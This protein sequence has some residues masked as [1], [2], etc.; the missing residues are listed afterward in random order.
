VTLTPAFPLGTA[1]LPG[2][3]VVLRVFESRY[4]D[5]VRQVLETDRTFVSALISAGSEVGGGDKRFDV[6]VLVEV[7]HVEQADIGLMLYGHAT[8]AVNITQWND[9]LSYPCAETSQQRSDWPE[10]ADSLTRSL[11]AFASDMD[12]FFSFLDGFNI[13]PPVPP[14]FVLSLLPHNGEK[15]TRIDV[16][17]HFWSVARLLPSTPLTRCELLA[18]VPLGEKITRAS[19]EIEHLRDIVRFRYG[20]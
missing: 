6:G 11:R 9:D 17:S 4:L 1:Y 8:R 2:D 13:S 10:S 18:D 3:A 16:E 5:L 15:L 14:G 12:N 19:E 7:D 20:N